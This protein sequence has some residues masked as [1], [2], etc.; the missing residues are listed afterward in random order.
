MG[1]RVRSDRLKEILIKRGLSYGELAAL[2][3]VSENTI[4]NVLQGRFEPT[5]KT[6]RGILKATGSKFDEIFQIIN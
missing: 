4:S 3:G 1:V 2:A 5:R 6:R